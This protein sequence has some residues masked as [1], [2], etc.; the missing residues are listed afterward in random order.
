MNLHEKPGLR[1]SVSSSSC[2]SLLTFP[3]GYS[4][5]FAD[6]GQNVAK[7]FTPDDRDLMS[8][9][10]LSIF[11][12]TP[13]QV[14]ESRHRS[15]VQWGGPMSEEEYFHRGTEVEQGESA[16]NGKLTVW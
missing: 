13:A 11:P 4:R 2:S 6:K 5:V 9:S 14:Q 12:A 7:F 15:F 16:R 8:L 3:Q 1:K 10:S